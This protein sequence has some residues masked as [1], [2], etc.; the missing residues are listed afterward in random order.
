MFGIYCA[1]WYM[2]FYRQVTLYNYYIIELKGLSCKYFYNLKRV[3]V[4]KLNSYS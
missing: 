3:F 4:F 1:I 2:G